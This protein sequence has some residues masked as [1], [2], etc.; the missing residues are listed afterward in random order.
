MKSAVQKSYK[1]QLFQLRKL[2]RETPVTQT[3]ICDRLGCIQPVASLLI[4]E[5]V[6]MEHAEK[7]Y[8]IQDANGRL[9][10]QV[11]KLTDKYLAR[12]KQDEAQK[13][14]PTQATAQAPALGVTPVEQQEFAFAESTAAD[15]PTAATV[16]EPAQPVI[17][18]PVQRPRSWSSFDLV[19]SVFMGGAFGIA[20]S[21][22]APRV[23]A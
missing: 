11:Y 14:T 15:T 2:M 23:L 16:D 10:V 21:M 8:K 22:I 6:A 7:T 1:L 3:M 4:R 20:I 17:E 12:L 18:A 19:L 9:A 13:E 5:L